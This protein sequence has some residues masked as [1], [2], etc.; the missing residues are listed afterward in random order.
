M[1]PLARRREHSLLQAVMAVSSGLELAD[2]LHRIVEAGVELTDA[3]FGALGVLGE[4]EGVA[5]FVHVGMPEVQATAIGSLP[6]GRGV[7]GLLIEHPEPIRLEDLRHHPA[8]VGFPENHPEM[9]T[10]LGVPILVRDKVFGN[11]YL[12]EKADGELFTQE[13]EDTVIALSAAAGIAIENA[14]LF[15]A[16]RQREQWQRAIAEIDNAVLSGSDAGEVIAKIAS[17]ARRLADAD[18]TVVALPDANGRLVV[19]IVDVLDP[20]E[21]ADSA[22]RWSVHRSIHDRPVVTSEAVAAW[23]SARLPTASPTAQAFV[24]GR[25]V[26]GDGIGP[27]G[28]QADMGPSISVPLRT[29]DRVMGALTLIRGAGEPDFSSD[30]RELALSFATQA[31][32]TL[33]LAESRR[34]HE[35]LALFEDRDRIAR[36]LHDL[37]IQRL[38]A[39]GMLL[40]GASRG[41]DLPPD[42]SQRLSRAVDELD[43][44]V[45]EIRQTI[46]D[47]QDSP[48]ESSGLRASIMAET[49]NVVSENGAS[50]SV[51][52]EGAV[53]SAASP[54]LAE[55]V[56]AV[57]RELLSNAARHS[58]ASRISVL[59]SATD[60]FSVSV[61]D[62]GVG[63]SED[64]LSGARRSGLSNAAHRAEI[65]GGDFELLA[66]E[67]G[68]TVVWRVPLT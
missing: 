39:T 4:G 5:E 26:G 14:R 46:F 23:T 25:L 66:R 18:I 63:L 52:F 44:T 53:D 40:Q 68:T 37:V 41:K 38:F 30:A 48:D 56:I 31:A 51:H 28:P 13:D 27:I 64:V 50:L 62:D 21:H 36:D 49:R 54:E 33:M 60:Q 32:M 67:P 3:T 34:E 22:S 16:A 47:L 59:V 17:R 65:L 8:A 35:R 55:H 7:L 58:R 6:R 11:L 19:E 57:C 61:S 12:T 43:A 15:E 42:V 9:G 1:S 20:E 24:T 29:S 45:K 2:T 10:F